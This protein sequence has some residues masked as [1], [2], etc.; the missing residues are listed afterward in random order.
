M[1]LSLNVLTPYPINP[2]M[3]MT[4]QPTPVHYPNRNQ[5][6]EMFFTKCNLAMVAFTTD[7]KQD[8]T[9]QTTHE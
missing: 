8:I 6:P 9:K 7:L 3:Q 2:L 5:G 4:S 1:T